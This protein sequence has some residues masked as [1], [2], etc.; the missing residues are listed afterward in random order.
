MSQVTVRVPATTANLG[1]GYDS[2]GVALRIYNRVTLSTGSPRE[3]LPPIVQAAGEAFFT[4]S[5]LKGFDYDWQIQ[6]EVPR[7]RGMGSSVTV[8]LGVLVALNELAGKPLPLQRLF[9]ICSDLEGHPDNAAPAAFGGFTVAGGSDVARFEVEADLNFV[10]LIPDFEVSTPE[11]RKVLP[12]TVDHRNAVLSAA[13][14]CR[15]TAAFASRNYRLLRGA[16][17]DGLHQPYRHPLI[18]FLFEAIQAGEQAGAI[19]GFLSGSGST[20]ACVT[21]ENPEAVAAAM[22]AACPCT[23]ARTVITQADNEGVCLL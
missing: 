22:L 14:A 18:P 4:D 8:R 16:F 5:G 11:A 19:G 3:A 10:L 20:V 6:G 1:P 13:N 2:L 7:S 23:N 9:E 21:L 15:I 17:E 12:A